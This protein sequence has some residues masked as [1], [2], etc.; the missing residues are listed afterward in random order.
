MV[1][2]RQTLEWWREGEFVRNLPDRFQWFGLSQNAGQFAM[3]GATLAVFVALAFSLKHLSAGRYVYATG[4]D[5]EAAR[6]AGI[7]PRLVTFAVFVLMGALTGLGA[8][9]NAARFPDVDPKSGTGLELQAIAA[10]VVGGVA[11]SGGRGNLWGVLA[12]A[13]LLSCIRPAM[14]FL[15]LPPEWEKAFQGC[16]ILLAVTADG[17]RSRKEKN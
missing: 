4:S 7:R 1:T 11:V 15:R 10:V 14:T 8:L 5:A 17:L 13:L 12:G 2:W 16:V 3:I 6:L 9:F